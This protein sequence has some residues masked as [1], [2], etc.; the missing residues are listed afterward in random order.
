MFVKGVTKSSYNKVHCI[1]T[2]IYSKCFPGVPR[3]QV[4]FLVQ[5]R[6]LDNFLQKNESSAFLEK[7]KVVW[8]PAGGP[9]VTLV[10]SALDRGGRVP[11]PGKKE[12]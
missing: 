9:Q 3:Y 11:F 4:E 7:V 2:L 8:K 1:I 12:M 5:N 6:D 10:E